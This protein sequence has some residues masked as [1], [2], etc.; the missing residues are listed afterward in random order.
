MMDLGVGLVL[1]VL[2]A[3]LGQVPTAVVVNRFLDVAGE[4]GALVARVTTDRPSSRWSGCWPS[5]SWPTC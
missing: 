4:P 3:S 1:Y 2:L 5:A